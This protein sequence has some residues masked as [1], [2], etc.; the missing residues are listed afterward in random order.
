MTRTKNGSLELTSTTH[1]D[2]KLIVRDN[3]YAIELLAV[4]RAADQRVRLTF[5]G[6]QLDALA[7]E[8]LRIREER[9]I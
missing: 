7:V 8:I 2:H 3:L 9:N 5:E 6:K 4:D 1:P